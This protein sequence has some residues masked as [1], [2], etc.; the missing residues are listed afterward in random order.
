MIEMRKIKKNT[1]ML[2]NHF[3]KV[4]MYFRNAIL[5]FLSGLVD[6]L[7]FLLL[8]FN[9]WLTFQEIWSKWGKSNK[10]TYMLLNHFSKVVM[11]FRNAI[12]WF[13]SGLVDSLSFLLL[14]FNLWLTFQEIWSKW[15]KS[16]KTLICFWITFK[17][18]NVYPQCNSMILSGLVDSLSFLLLIFNLWLTFQE[19]WSKWGKHLYASESLFKG[20]NVF[21]QCNSMIF[22]WFSWFPIIPVTNFQFV[23]NISGDMIEMR[24]TLICFWI[25]FSKVVMYF[26]NAILWFLSGL[27]DSHHSC[28]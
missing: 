7:S 20:C 28:Y 15:G 1:Y 17:G 2:L 12:L 4:V 6:S 18:C 25:T 19:I 27:V 8:I 21:P 14:I 23:T 26:R 9:L 5:W 16:N 3:S 24:K 22:E 11:Y 10:N 13:L